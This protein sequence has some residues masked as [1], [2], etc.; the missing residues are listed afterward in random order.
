MMITTRCP[1]SSRRDRSPC[2]RHSGRALTTTPAIDATDGWPREQGFHLYYTL[3]TWPTSTRGGCSGSGWAKYRTTLVGWIHSA[4]RRRGGFVSVIPLPSRRCAA[5]IGVSHASR[6]CRG[7]SSGGASGA[8][9]RAPL[10][11][12]LVRRQQP[13]RSSERA[14]GQRG[15]RRYVAP[16]G[17]SLS[18][19]VL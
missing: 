1:P 5:R 10:F 8:D 4:P 19:A 11:R 7:K 12:P 9:T 3:P 17:F 6:V 16:L 13:S 15:H 2:R 14:A 18:T